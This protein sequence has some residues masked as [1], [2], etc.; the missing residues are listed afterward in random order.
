MRNGA[1]VFVVLVASAA[2]CTWQFP[3][4]SALFTLATGEG[5]TDRK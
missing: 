4:N 5:L 2:A 3:L 1:V